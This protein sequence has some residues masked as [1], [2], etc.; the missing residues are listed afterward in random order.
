MKNQEKDKVLKDLS[1]NGYPESFINNACKPTKKSH[2]TESVQLRGRTC[3]PYVK[4]LSE[5]LKRIL[6]KAGVRTALK[7]CQTLADVFR[8]PKERPTPNRVKGI[9]YKVKCNSCSFT[10]IGE[11]KRTW[12]TRWS[13]HK[14]GVRKHNYSAVKDHAETTGHE[15]RS[16]DVE[17]LERGVINHQKRLFLEAVHSVKTKDSVNEHIELPSAYLPLITSLQ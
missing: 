1:L 13:E 16:T 4:G 9:V 6:E 3:L 14:P 2:Q 17:I 8:V 5:R 7:P 12:E 11:T 15:V 10:Y